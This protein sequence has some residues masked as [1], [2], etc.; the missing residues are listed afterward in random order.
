MAKVAIIDCNPN[1][2]GV[3]GLVADSL[4][5]APGVDECLLVQ[6]A[7]DG[8][9]AL[10]GDGELETVVLFPLLAASSPDLASR[11]G[12]LFVSGSTQR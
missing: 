6:Q 10:M 8:W 9:N 12:R 4:A 2:D 1:G 11:P 3:A 5:T 7:P